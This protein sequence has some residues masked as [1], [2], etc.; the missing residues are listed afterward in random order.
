MAK[1]NVDVLDMEIV[2]PIIEIIKKYDNFEKEEN[3]RYEEYEKIRKSEKS[4]SEN[5]T[6]K[7]G[8]VLVVYA[9]LFIGVSAF[10]MHAL[11]EIVDLKL[12]LKDLNTKIFESEK[13]IDSLNYV[14]KSDSYDMSLSKI[15]HESKKLGFT[16][17][18]KV[19]YIKFK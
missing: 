6:Y 14:D 9:V 16:E 8:K 12:E 17:D 1:S 5:H 7:L 18:T 2:N 4:K 15:E 11:Y 13:L 10:K 19:E 3:A